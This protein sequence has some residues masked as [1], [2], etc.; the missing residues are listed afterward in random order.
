MRRFVNEALGEVALLEEHVTDWMA[1]HPDPIE[2]D[3]DGPLTD[4][5]RVLVFASCIKGTLEA[6]IT[7]VQTAGNIPAGYVPSDDLAASV[8]HV[9][10]LEGQL[11]EVTR[12]ADRL[13]DERAAAESRV[14]RLRSIVDACAAASGGDTAGASDDFAALVPGEIKAMRDRLEQRDAV[15]RELGEVREAAQAVRE[16]VGKATIAI[17]GNGVRAALDRLAAALGKERWN[18]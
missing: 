11:L 1:E 7:S 18:E 3:P 17:G 14:M 13:T 4:R 12:A 2:D 15:R 9:R 8:A 6:G 5:Q 16:A 10:D